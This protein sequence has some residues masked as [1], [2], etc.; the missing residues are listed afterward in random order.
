MHRLSVR[1]LAIVFGIKKFHFYLYGRSFLLVTDH[2]PLTRIFGPKSGIPPLA[3]AR[4]Q[5]WALLLSGYQ[6]Q[7]VYRSSGD[8]ANADM[9]SRLPLTKKDSEEEDPDENYIFQAVVDSLPVTAKR[10]ADQTRKDPLLVKVLEFTLSGWSEAECKNDSLRPYW[11]RREELSL[12][13][14]CLLWGRRVVVPESLQD[15]ML[16][17]LHECHPGMCRMKSL[18]RSYVWWPGIDEDI[19]MRVRRCAL[20]TDVQNSPKKVP[21]LLWPWATSPWERIHLDFAEIK[22]QNFLIVVDSYSKWL[23]VF[24]MRQTKASDT[25][26][27]LRTLFARYGLP[28]QVVSDNGPQFISE[29]FR[30]FLR[31]NNV[32]HTLC[33]PYHPSSN[34]LAEKYVQTFKRLFGKTST[35]L[36]LKHRVAKSSV[37]L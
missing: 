25:I 13:D 23:E 2:K 19:E 28:V 26:E 32:K 21:L 24:P 35:E 6:Y 12:D 22:G 31:L 11:F 5:R 29:E 14:G 4:M 9:L 36:S 16:D 30:E 34:G 15:Q 7:I 33:P 1:G 8:N 20:C 3:A 17:E 27:V 10:I 37:Q 18:A